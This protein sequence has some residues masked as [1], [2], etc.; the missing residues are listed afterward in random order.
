MS[1]VIAVDL[2]VWIRGSGMIS[3]AYRKVG[4]HWGECF[5]TR[6]FAR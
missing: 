2:V 6:F 4:R 3:V 5:S 1:R